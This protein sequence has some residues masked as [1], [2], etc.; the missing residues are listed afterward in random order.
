[1]FYSLLDTPNS[2]LSQDPRQN[3]VGRVF[4]LVNI[5]QENS[6]LIRLNKNKAILK[7]S[8]HNQKLHRVL[9]GGDICP[10][11]FVGLYIGS[12]CQKQLTT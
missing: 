1:M 9:L 11:D 6:L 2:L 5:M 7:E 12:L 8:L 3:C 10:C 4:E